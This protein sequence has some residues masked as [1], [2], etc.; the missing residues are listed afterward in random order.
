MSGYVIDRQP[1]RFTENRAQGTIYFPPVGPDID[2]AVPAGVGGERRADHPNFGSL[3]VEVN[4]INAVQIRSHL[5]QGDPADERWRKIVHASRR[6]ISG[7]VRFDNALSP[8]M[9]ST[10]R[11]ERDFTTHRCGRGMPQVHRI[12]RDTIAAQVLM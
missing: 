2:T 3:N 7:S 8:P 4:I 5:I 11:C 9:V 6:D 12:I 10:A 1:A